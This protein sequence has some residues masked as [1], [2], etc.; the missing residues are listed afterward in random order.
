MRNRK[1]KRLM[2][3]YAEGYKGGI[4]YLRE[5]QKDCDEQD[6]WQTLQISIEL[7][8]G[9]YEMLPIVREQQTKEGKNNV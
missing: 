5:M 8:E 1:L 7:L 4:D 6:D 9:E 3:A 2:E